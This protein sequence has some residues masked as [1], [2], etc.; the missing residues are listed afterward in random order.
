MKIWKTIGLMSGSSLDG[1][2]IAYS[3]FWE[4]SNRWYYKL[5]LGETINYSGDW[6]K[7]LINIRNYSPAKIAELHIKYGELLGEYAN[8]FIKKHSLSPDLIAS[9]GHTVFH[10]PDQGYTFQ[11]G[12]GEAIANI[13]GIV[14]VNDFRT[15]DI[16]LG[17]QGAPLAPLGDELLFNEYDACINL[18]GIA[19]I[20]FSKNGERVA[21]DIGPANQLLNYLANQLTLDFDEDGKIA[22]TGKLNSELYEK[23]SADRFY[24]LPI[25]RSLSNEYVA[26]NFIPVID[27]IDAPV[28]DKLYT[29]TIHIVDQLHQSLL[30]ASKTEKATF[31]P[32]IHK[33][34][35]KSSGN[36][37]IT[38]GGS[39]NSFLI[40]SL[41]DI[42][43]YSIEVPDQMLV[44]Y[45]EALVFALMGVLRVNNRINCL[46]SAT[47]AT[48]DSSAGVIHQP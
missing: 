13:T 26:E 12:E 36:V 16:T 46:A 44:D 29:C 7:I 39:K 32:T 40:S 33:G 14:T 27:S 30:L 10:K 6:L 45:K 18:G 41:K 21:C 9:H 31:I 24:L 2:D 1:L 42:S 47:G 17:G 20:S 43:R 4:E 5:L 11:L 3:E 37:L 48:K 28:N 35:S 8:R 22:S 34:I 19:N 15:K 38:G 23:L 25:P